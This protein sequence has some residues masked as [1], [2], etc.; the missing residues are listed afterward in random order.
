[1]VLLL[2]L[3]LQRVTYASRRSVRLRDRRVDDSCG[4]CQGVT[5]FAGKQ[6]GEL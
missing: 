2:L 4:A 5:G 3:L 6:C 1:M